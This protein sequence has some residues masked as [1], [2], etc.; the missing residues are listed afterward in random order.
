M[1][2]LLPQVPFPLECWILQRRC[3]SHSQTF[4]SVFQH[5]SKAGSYCCRSIPDKEDKV[6]DLGVAF[7]YGVPENHT[8]RLKSRPEAFTAPYFLDTGSFSA[9]STWT[10]GYEAYYRADRWLFG[11]EYWWM[12][13]SSP[14]TNNPVVNGGDIVATYLFNDASRV[15]NTA[16]G[17]FRAVSPKRSVFQGGPGAWELV[18]RYSYINLDSQKLT[19][20]TFARIT[21]MV[22]WHMS[23]NMR[24]E[25]AYGYG[26]LDRFALHCATPSSSKAAFNCSS[27]TSDMGMRH[28]R[29]N[30]QLSPELVP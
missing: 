22:N 10:L 20:G 13:I 24:L 19:G 18:L 21:P 26:R 3:L 7:R 16:G 14:S 27:K 2:R 30:V 15:Y 4:S 29:P 1:A 5:G 12:H 28:F 17:F 9:N 23:N 25:M 8:L 11:S 6:L